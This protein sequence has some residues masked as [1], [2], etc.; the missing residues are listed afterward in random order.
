M[1]RKNWPIENKVGKRPVGNSP[2]VA[3]HHE[4]RPWASIPL[5]GPCKTGSINPIFGLALW[6]HYPF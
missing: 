6:T 2:T 5:D 3:L 4:H 1:F